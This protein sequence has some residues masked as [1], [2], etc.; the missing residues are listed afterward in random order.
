MRQYD[1]SVET[2]RDAHR[3][4]VAGEPRERERRPIDRQLGAAGAPIVKQLQRKCR[5][6]PAEALEIN[7]CPA[8]AAPMTV[9]T[10]PAVLSAARNA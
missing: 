10:E 7:G 8:G 6:E 9:S 5:V 1:G 3:L 4:D 2:E